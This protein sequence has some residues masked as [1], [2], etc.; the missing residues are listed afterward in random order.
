MHVSLSVRV[1]R[2]MKRQREA[3]GGGGGGGGGGDEEGDV[4]GED[5][6]ERR[7]GGSWRPLTH[8][9]YHH[10]TRLA[11]NATSASSKSRQSLEEKKLS[12]VT[13]SWDR[14]R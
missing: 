14:S 8:T 9:V 2:E 4:G 12:P 3:G 10:P 11:S 13:I 6:L 1:Q 7:R 5:S